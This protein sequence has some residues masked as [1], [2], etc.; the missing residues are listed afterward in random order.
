MASESTPP[1]D[2]AS[3][4]WAGFHFVRFKPTLTSPTTRALVPNLP[5]GYRAAQAQRLGCDPDE[6]E[7][8]PALELPDC[9]PAREYLTFQN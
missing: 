5:D 7:L 6:L 1:E 4:T 3:A 9:R 2:R 8:L